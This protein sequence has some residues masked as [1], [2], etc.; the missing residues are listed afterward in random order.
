MKLSTEE[1]IKMYLLADCDRDCLLVSR[2]YGVGDPGSKFELR[3]QP[4]SSI[5]KG[6][7]QIVTNEKNELAVILSTVENPHVC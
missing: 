7:K 3:Q 4:V 5:R 2:M 6:K 1:I